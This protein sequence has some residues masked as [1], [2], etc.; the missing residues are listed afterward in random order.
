MQKTS[1]TFNPTNDNS[2]PGSE[3]ASVN[4]PHDFG[5]PPDKAAEVRYASHATLDQDPGR[6]QVRSNDERDGRRDVGVGVDS[7]GVGAGSGGDIDP[8]IVGVGT[9]GSGI[10]QTP[11][12]RNAPAS[13]TQA[14]ERSRPNARPRD[15]Q[16]GS[17]T[18][19]ESGLQDDQDVA[20]TGADA[21]RTVAG[22]SFDDANAGEIS[23]DESNGTD[24]DEGVE[25][26]ED[27]A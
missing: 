7:S 12:S 10:A 20:P 5:V 15:E 8:D 6:R 27:N 17:L 4:R 11:P 9:G 23:A 21:I 14:R 2:R 19:N 3:P 24:N 13:M 25:L 22:D 16:A 18:N 1:P 26:N